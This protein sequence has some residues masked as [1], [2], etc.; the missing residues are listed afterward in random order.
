[1]LQQLSIQPSKENSLVLVSEKYL[2][3]LFI[4]LQNLYWVSLVFQR[5]TY[6][7]L[8]HYINYMK[9][10]RKWKQRKQ[11]K[12]LCELLLP[13]IGLEFRKPIWH[14]LHGYNMT[15]S[16]LHVINMLFNY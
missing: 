2:G 7:K 6:L 16:I 12:I 5:E 4:W 14:N 1:M 8:L 13:Q 15:A 3:E 9:K 11:D 10:E